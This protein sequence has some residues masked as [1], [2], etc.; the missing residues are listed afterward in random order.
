MTKKLEITSEVSKDI[1]LKLME[2]TPL[3]TICKSKGFPSLSKVYNWIS[4]DKEFANQIM[5]SRRIGSQTY[6]DRMIEE[7]ENADSKNIMVIREKLHHYR[8]LASKLLGQI[9]GDKKE[10]QVDQ[11][12]E[13][14]WNTDDDLTY[15]N[16]ARNVT[17][18]G[19]THETNKVSHA[20]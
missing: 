15:E 11:K 16:E 7:L 6:L 12:I 14:K 13:I 19:S 1:Q 8:W 5:I 17:N 20:T 18:S 10:V 9:Y 2:G 3:T 4:E